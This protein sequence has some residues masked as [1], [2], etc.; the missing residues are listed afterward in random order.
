MNAA[1]Y[2]C[3][4]YSPNEDTGCLSSGIIKFTPKF[5]TCPGGGEIKNMI[6]TLQV[7]SY[8]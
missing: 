7:K 6:Y 1:A 2:E 3:T 4:V 5:C 8:Y